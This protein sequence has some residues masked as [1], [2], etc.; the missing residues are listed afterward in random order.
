MFVDYMQSGIQSPRRPKIPG[1]TLT[2][3]QVIMQKSPPRKPSLQRSS[4]GSVELS[5]KRT[6]EHQRYQIA[7]E[8]FRRGI[9]DP[10]FIVQRI[11][12]EQVRI[13]E[14][15]KNRLRR[16][17]PWRGDKTQTTRFNPDM[18]S[19]VGDEDREQEDLEYPGDAVFYLPITEM[20][21]VQHRTGGGY[22]DTTFIDGPEEEM[23]RRTEDRFRA[24]TVIPDTR[25]PLL[26]LSKPGNLSTVVRELG[27]NWWFNAEA[28][29]AF[30]AKGAQQHQPPPRP[31]M[32]PQPTAQDEEEEE[33]E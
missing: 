20:E 27:Q 5:Y 31:I 6:S 9:D 13:L 3:S 18:K 19:F 24:D 15:P 21:P 7:K 14:K 22:K 26:R 12:D 4:S 10:D 23:Q 16:N 29:E 32:P 33:A 11:N 28:V 2:S 30:R 25:K 8:R 17:E 1:R